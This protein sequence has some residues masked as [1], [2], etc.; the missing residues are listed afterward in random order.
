MDSCETRQSPRGQKGLG[1]WVESLREVSK[2]GV[3]SAASGLKI[4]P[5][6]N[7]SAEPQGVQS[8]R[9]GAEGLGFGVKG[10]EGTVGRCARTWKKGEYG[11]QTLGFRAS[12]A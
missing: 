8:Y 12:R 4:H 7:L 3:G 5:L 6:L 11:P 10:L 1:F 9:F 2:K